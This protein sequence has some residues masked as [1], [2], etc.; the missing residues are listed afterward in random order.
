MS[1]TKKLYLTRDS[2]IPY[3]YCFWDDKPDGMDDDGYWN[4]SFIRGIRT[5]SSLLFVETSEEFESQY[6]IVLKPGE[7]A[8]V[9][10]KVNVICQK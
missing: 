2:S 3:D 10:M 4:V 1:N 8:E 5:D 6:H 7:I 9:T